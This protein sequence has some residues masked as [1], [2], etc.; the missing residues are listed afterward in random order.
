MPGTASDAF[1]TAVARRSCG[2]WGQSEQQRGEA[3]QMAGRSK[4]FKGI[5]PVCAVTAP[6]WLDV[7]ATIDSYG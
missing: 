1:E 7:S 4:P 5:I 3:A 2:V 6:D